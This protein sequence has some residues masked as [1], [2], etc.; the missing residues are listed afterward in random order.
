MDVMEIPVVVAILLGSIKAC[1]VIVGSQASHLLS[2]NV[3][4]VME[5]VLSEDCQH[6]NFQI[7][8]QNEHR[9]GNTLV[10]YVR[11]VAIK[12]P[13]V[14][15]IKLLLN[16]VTIVNNVQLT[17]NQLPFTIRVDGTVI[18]RTRDE[19]D[20]WIKVTLSSSR[21]RVFWNRKKKIKLVAPNHYKNRLC[22]LCGTFDGN[23]S[24][25]L[26]LRNGTVLQLTGLT[27]TSDDYSLIKEYH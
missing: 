5:T 7:T 10:K 2:M 15:I 20:V 14:A 3:A 21:V 12:I 24:N 23:K 13:K 6:E 11:S 18:E 16:K 25:D 8:V 19:T 22:G 4:S 1:V 9:H 27:Y 17:E 26:T